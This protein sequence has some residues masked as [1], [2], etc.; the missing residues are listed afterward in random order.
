MPESFAYSPCP[1]TAAAPPFLRTTV[2]ALIPSRS[3][4]RLPRV[5]HGA[6]SWNASP[7]DRADPAPVTAS[8]RYLAHRG[9]AGSSPPALP[10]S[11]L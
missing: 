4:S 2:A 5:A 6:G 7:P 10:P 8:Q 9:G 11:S 1:R 3:M